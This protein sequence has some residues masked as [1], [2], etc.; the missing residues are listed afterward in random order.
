MLHYRVDAPRGDEEGLLGFALSFL[1][2][3]LCL[4]ILLFGT[5]HGA[6]HFCRSLLLDWSGCCVAEPG[7]VCCVPVPNLDA[8]L[9]ATQ[10]GGQYPALW[11]DSC[12]AVTATSSSGLASCACRMQAHRRGILRV[13]R[14]RTACCC[15]MPFSYCRPIVSGYPV[16]VPLGTHGINSSTS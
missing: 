14:Q 7:Q 4:L 12:A 8:D 9:S 15:V 10:L 11:V 13:R 16:R 6:R 5:S 3:P 2:L 1:A